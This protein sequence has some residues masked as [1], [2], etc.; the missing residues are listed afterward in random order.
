VYGEYW[1]VRGLGA[2][3]IFS[4]ERYL[5]AVRADIRLDESLLK[6]RAEAGTRGCDVPTATAASGAASAV[7][8]GPFFRLCRQ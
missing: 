5:H 3:Q 6:G 7:P 4:E 8:V 1:R 2:D